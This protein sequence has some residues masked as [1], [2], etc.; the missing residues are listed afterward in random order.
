MKEKKERKAE[1]DKQE[2]RFSFLKL[3][4]KKKSN[5]QVLLESHLCKDFNLI[6]K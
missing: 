2:I 4:L 6:K 3:L 5:N 1:S